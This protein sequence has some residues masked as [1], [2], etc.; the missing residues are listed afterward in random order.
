MRVMFI[1]LLFFLLPFIG[2]G[3]FVYFS[4]GRIDASEVLK[5]KQFFWLVG[6]GIACVVIGLV[7][8]ATFQ[9]GSPEAVYVPTRYENGVLVPGG[10]R[11]PEEMSDADREAL[12]GFDRRVDPK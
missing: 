9:T 1:N 12:R 10:F 3:L 11:T 8:L 2:Y 7:V 6:G 5:G 4:K